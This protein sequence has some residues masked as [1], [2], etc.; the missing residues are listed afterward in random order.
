MDFSR[1]LNASG[2]LHARIRGQFARSFRPCPGLAHGRSRMEQILTFPRCRATDTDH[3][4]QAGPPY[5]WRRSREDIVRACMS[6]I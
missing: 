6:L 4:L 3:E 2:D 1:A 5:P